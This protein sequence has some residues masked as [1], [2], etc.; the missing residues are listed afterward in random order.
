MHS[1]QHKLNM[2]CFWV[3]LGFARCVEWFFVSLCVRLFC[4]WCNTMTFLLQLFLFQLLRGLSYCHARHILHRWDC[5]F[6]RLLLVHLVCFLPARRYASAGLCYSDVSVWTSVCHTLVLCLAERKQNREMYTVWQPH[7]SS[8]W[9]GVIH[10]KIRK[11]SPQRNVPNEGGLGF[12]GDFRPICRH[13]SR[14][15][16]FRHKVTM[17]W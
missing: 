17:G 14:M 8:F 11:V 9:R 1:K 5:G 4:G 12:F 3:H 10:R 2:C 16:H 13:I 7:H 6:S 15:V